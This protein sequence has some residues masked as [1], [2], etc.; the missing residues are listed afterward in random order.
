MVLAAGEGT[1]MRSARP[2]PLHL[3]CGRPMLLH[4]LDAL[5]GIDLDRTIIVVGHGAEQ[6]TKKVQ[7]LAPSR[8]RLA[9]VEQP[10]QRGT[11]DAVLYGLSALDDDDL[12]E[13]SDLLVLPGDTPLLRP[14]TIA[15][16][17]TQHRSS[18][19]VATL[20]TTRMPDPS[21]YGR[22][23]RDK[24]GNITGVVE[25]RDASPEQLGIDEINTSIYC[26]HRALL[27]PAL[28]R[29]SPQ[30][31]QGEY[32]LTD[33][34]A[35]LAEAGHPVDA[36][37][38][39]DRSEPAGVNDRAQ[40]AAAEGEL[41]ARTN[42]RWLAAGVNML[43]PAQTFVEVTVELAPDVTLFPGAILQGRT[44]VG[45]GAEIGPNTRL[46]DTFVGAGSV[47]ENSVARGA[48]IGADA[49]VGPYA[50]LSPGDHIND[51]QRTGPF[52]TAGRA[53]E[54]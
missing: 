19:A 27:A 38:V 48:V 30:N 54:G 24:N 9:F 7:E 13:S 4:V 5:E 50:V 23:V 28:R 15:A 44:V 34:I 46:V 32:Y 20:L 33:V 39:D 3:L 29:L 53:E 49:R 43:E 11:G 6:V 14:D 42:R 31:A 40:L 47:V 17:V 45:P 2:K 21:G 51:G 35:V 37:I 18:N 1:R 10:V 52:Y 36:L 8:L 12:G 25:Q 26:F 16:L 22:V 41:R